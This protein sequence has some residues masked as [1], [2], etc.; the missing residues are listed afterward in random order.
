MAKRLAQAG[1][2][3]LTALSAALLHDTIEDTNA[4]RET[5]ERLFGESVARL[6]GAVTLEPG[7]S[8]DEQEHRYLKRIIGSSPEAIAIKAA[9]LTDNL[10]DSEGRPR[11]RILRMCDRARRFLVETNRR[12]QNAPP[13]P[14]L[15]LL[16]ANLLKT[17]LDLET[18]LGGRTA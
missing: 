2:G 11:W 13:E 15:L 7:I 10:L 5:I 16:K 4:D 9:D 8:Y 1:F 3:D 14:R 17:I 6:V 18:W 12:S